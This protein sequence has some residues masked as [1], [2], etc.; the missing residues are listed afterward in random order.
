M[1]ISTI[2]SSLVQQGKLAPYL[3]VRTIR[4]AKRRLYM[5][6][7]MSQKFADNT[8]AVNLLVGRGT[9]ESALNSWVLGDHIHDNG[10]GGS[11]FLKR[12]EPPPPEIWEIRITEPSIQVR[13]FGRFADTD[14]FVATDMLT[15]TSLGRKGSATWKAACKNC[16]TD[17]DLLFGSNGP[18]TG[19]KVKDYVSENCDDFPLHG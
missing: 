19:V 3:P 1:S 7:N 2:I 9:I 18:H 10:N 6:K 8:S 15:R 17:W 16:E 4:K 11:G 14:T 12:L 13:V 5:T